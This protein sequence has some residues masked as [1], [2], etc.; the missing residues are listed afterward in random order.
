M[1]RA[2][3]LQVTDPGAAGPPWAKID[4]EVMRQAPWVPLFN[5]GRLNFVLSRLGNYQFNPVWFELFDQ[6]CVR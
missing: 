4:R 1:R 3:A 6:M 5:S 2:L